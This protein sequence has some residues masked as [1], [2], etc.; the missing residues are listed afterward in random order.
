MSKNEVQKCTYATIQ[1]KANASWPI[2]YVF[3]KMFNNA[4]HHIVLLDTLDNMIMKFREDMKHS[5]LKKK[6]E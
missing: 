5:Y 2:I 6:Q 1:L 3:S 4:L